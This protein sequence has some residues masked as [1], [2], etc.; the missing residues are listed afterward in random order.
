MPARLYYGWVIVAT[1]LAINIATAPLNPVVFSFFIAPISKE[2]GWSLGAISLALT[3]RLLVS[4]VTAPLIGLIIDR[5]GPKWLG[6]LA[7]VAAGV[8]LVG[9]FYVRQLW[10]L[11]LLFAISGAVGLGGGPGGNLLTAV[12]VAKWFISKRGRATSIATTG[13]A[14][15]T[16]ISIPAG[17]WM[18]QTIGW[19]EA[20]VVFGVLVTAIIVPLS[21]LFLRG[22][23]SDLGLEPDGFGEPRLEPLPADLDNQQNA[24][25]EGDWTAREALRHP[26]SWLILAAL[27]VGGFALTGTL[28]H[29]VAYW[30]GTGMSPSMVAIGIAMD[31]FTV[32][33]SVIIFGLIGERVKIRYLGLF[34]AL[35]FSL[36][37]LPMIWSTG[38]TYT[39]IAHSMIW[40]IGAG[41]YITANNLI[42]PNYFGR[43]FLGTIRG[44][45]FPVQVAATSLGPPVY[46]FLL[47]TGLD[48]ITLWMISTGLFAMAGFLLFMARPPNRKVSQAVLVGDSGAKGR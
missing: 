34:G 42:W 43:R 30:E 12:P 47:D 22:S 35:G 39:I 4:G 19:R 41:A 40:A 6:L 36:S 28:L 7:G 48:P 10:L 29:R 33:F 3:F 32:I 1:G 44:V 21:F 31:P 5:F 18:I 26:V 13:M 2:M 24:A 25:I 8:S 15:G 9:L 14:I 20:W 37:M 11:Y 45:V 16:V 23:P 27:S 38:Q 17:Q 46:G